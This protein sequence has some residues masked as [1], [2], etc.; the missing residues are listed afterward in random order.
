MTF[1]KVLTVDL[2]PVLTYVTSICTTQV[3][4]VASTQTWALSSL[5]F[6]LV[7]QIGIKVILFEGFG[8]KDSLYA[9]DRLRFR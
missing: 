7:S 6:T 3:L 5:L 1:S 8:F 2:Y 9:I 4:S